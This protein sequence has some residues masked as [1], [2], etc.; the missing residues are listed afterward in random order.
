MR[1]P[2]RFVVIAAANR[3]PPRASTSIRVV[4]V[5]ESL[6]DPASAVLV[7]AGDGMRRLTMLLVQMTSSPPPL[8][9]SLHWLMVTE[10]P[11]AI[12]PVAVQVNSTNVPPLPEPLHCV[13]AASVTVAGNGLQP[14]VMLLPEP[15]H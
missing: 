5:A 1:T 11:E 6:V 9:E 15:T 10:R 3:N 4:T 7:G 2:R 13:I 14:V 12:V 8:A